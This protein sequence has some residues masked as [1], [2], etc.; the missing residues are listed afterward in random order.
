MAQPPVTYYVGCAFLD[1]AN[2]AWYAEMNQPFPV[3]PGGI[4]IF[5][6]YRNTPASNTAA[7]VSLTA[8]PTGYAWMVTGIIWSYNG[9]PTGGNLTINDSTDEF[10]IDITSAGPGFVPF[11]TGFIFIPG[12]AVTVTLAAGGSGVQGKVGLIGCRVI[13]M[14]SGLGG[15]GVAGSGTPAVLPPA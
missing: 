12:Q 14:Q 9:T 5:S 8:P 11:N 2:T 7:V 6:T 10:D 1:P 13:P 4:Q 3:A 15:I